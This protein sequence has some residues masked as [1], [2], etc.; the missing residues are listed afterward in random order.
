MS[1]RLRT[2]VTNDDGVSSEGL[3]QLALAAVHN[4]LDVFVAAPIDDASGTSAALTATEADGRVVVENHT[5][6]DLDGVPVYGVAAV[7]A[8]ITLIA[9][10]G[11][12][13]PPP[14]IVLSGINRGA[15]TGH[16]ILHSG[17]VG[18]A[19][20]A[21]S[22]GCRALAISLS[23]SVASPEEPLWEMAASVADRMIP[24]L[25]AQ[26][27]SAMLNV[28]VPNR[29]TDE[30]KGIRK[31]R[32]ARFGAVQTKIAEHGRGFVRVTVADID[33]ELEP[34]TDA[35]LLADGFVSVTPLLAI[36]EAHD[37]ELPDLD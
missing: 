2:L 18:A 5:L 11:A 12:F 19:L 21:C 36:C 27:G 23:N 9:T 32:L 3:R 37:L 35:A 29:P 15:N 34:G 30:L 17:T 33:A 28:N 6:P 4:D 25:L 10:R 14:D 20:T 24:L 13:G 31:G 16:A 8:F 1:S 26:D 22:N 7:P